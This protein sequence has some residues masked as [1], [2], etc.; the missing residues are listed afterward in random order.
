MRTVTGLYDS[1]DEAQDAVGELEASGIP[2]S[3]ISIVA[4]NSEDWY[5][6]DEPSEAAEDAGAGA[7]IGAVVGG[8]GGLL[9][10]LGVM[11]IPGV[12]PV[13]A[14][15]WLAAT[16]VGAVAGAAVGGAAGGIIGALTDSGVSEQDAN[17]YAEGIRRGGTLVTARASDDLAPE[18][19]RILGQST[20]VDVASRRRDYEA[21]GWTAFDPAAP[22]YAPGEARRIP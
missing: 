6:N 21:E 5:E 22:A 3:D 12:G 9:T 13:V 2:S 17:V 4:N 20:A 19:E 18:A 15:G 7:G 16:A 14:A 11:A 1:Y 8:A 10:G